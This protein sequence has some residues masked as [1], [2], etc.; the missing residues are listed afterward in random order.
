MTV[1]AASPRS[2]SDEATGARELGTQVPGARPS[3]GN[4]GWGV[5]KCCECFIVWQGDWGKDGWSKGGW[6]EEHAWQ[7]TRSLEVFRGP[8]AGL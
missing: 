8:A 1:F 7:G 4:V 3:V 6:N 2:R 5:Q